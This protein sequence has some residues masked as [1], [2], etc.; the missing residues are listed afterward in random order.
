MTEP[1][2]SPEDVQRAMQHAGLDPDRP[3]TEQLTEQIGQ[4]K[5]D[6]T[7]AAVARLEQRINELVSQQ[8]PEPHPDPRQVFASQY[9]SALSAAQ[10]RWFTPGGE[11]VE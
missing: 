6:D 1:A 8:N 2:I 9:L 11:H 10:S 7:A 4:V 3:L 5:R